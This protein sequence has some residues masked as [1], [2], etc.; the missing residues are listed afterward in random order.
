MKKG[1]LTIG[2]FLAFT[3]TS[4][5][6][7]VDTL[8]DFF[9]GTPTVYGLDSELPLDSG[10]LA[11]NNIYGDLAKMQKFDGTHGSV[12]AGGNITSVLVAVPVKVDGGG[13]FDV[14]IWA[15]NAGTPDATPLATK[16][17]TIASVDTTSAGY[18][19]AEGVVVY[20]V[21]A[22]FASPVAIPSSHTFWAGV[23]L[24]TGANDAISLLHNTD[25]D[26]T[27]ATTHTGEFWSDGSFYTFGDANNWGVNVALAVYP[28]VSYTAN[29]EEIASSEVS[30]YPNPANNELNI[31]MNENISTVSVM[32]TE[33]KVVSTQAANGVSTTVDLNGLNSGMYMF[34]VTTSNGST[35]TSTFVKK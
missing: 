26:F 15:D 24:P 5:A 16:T 34:Q 3:L 19:V 31:K 22:T 9:T 12:I 7:T 29:V 6:Q 33:G 17:I 28:V 4:T 2:A 1:L 14:A 13:S 23:I 27:D 32:T 20:N 8:T 35:Y 18:S 25:G 11:G 30:V 10:Y 21:T